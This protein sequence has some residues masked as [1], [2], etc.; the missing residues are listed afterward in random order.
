MRY[1]VDE[2]SLPKPAPERSP[3]PRADEVATLYA[4]IGETLRNFD[5]Q[6]RA[7]EEELAVLRL[8]HNIPAVAGCDARPEP[9]NDN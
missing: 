3:Q 7:A 5:A 8:L 2:K 4:E 9:Q 1:V 6:I